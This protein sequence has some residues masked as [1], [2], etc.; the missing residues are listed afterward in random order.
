MIALLADPAWEV[1]SAA[2]RALGQ[3]GQPTAVYELNQA[4]ADSA[5]WVR[6]NAA[7]SLLRLGK[8]GRAALETNSTRHRDAF[9]RDIC[10]Q[11]LEERATPTNAGGLNR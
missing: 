2:A 1:R 10:R 11:V 3:L 7:S 6:F 5:W 9:A 8:E 4:L